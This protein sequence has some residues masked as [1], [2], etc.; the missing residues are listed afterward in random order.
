M[1]RAPRNSPGAVSGSGG[2][3]TPVRR[4]NP[5]S[6]SPNLTK[7]AHATRIWEKANETRN[8]RRKK[9]NTR[10]HGARATPA[11][12]IRGGVKLREPPHATPEILEAFRLYA[13]APGRVPGGGPHHGVHP[14]ARA[15]R[16]VVFADT[17]PVLYSMLGWPSSSQEVPGVHARAPCSGADGIQPRAYAPG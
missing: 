10:T 12:R 4:R 11:G 8:I 16:P 17:R 14:S 3:C 5:P 1:P 2:T 6:S 7:P 13:G 9:H 15:P